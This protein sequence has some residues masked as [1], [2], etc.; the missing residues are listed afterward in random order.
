VN[1]NP[2]IFYPFLFE[3]TTMRSHFPRVYSMPI[4]FWFSGDIRLSPDDI[5]P[6][7]FEN[8]ESR[9]DNC[10]ALI[11]VG[12]PQPYCPHCNKDIERQ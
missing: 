6:I 5:P 11:P 1:L 3:E 12:D 10:G 4:S 8:T 7:D 9:C 2:F